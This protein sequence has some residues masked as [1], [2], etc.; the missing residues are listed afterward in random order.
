MATPLP[1]KP[2]I[3]VLP[4]KNM[5][6]DPEQEYFANGMTEDLI[7]DLSQVSA[8][9]VFPQFDIV[10]KNKPV[11]AKQI[12]RELGVRYLLEGSVQR[13]GDRVRINAQLIDGS[14][15]AICGR[16]DTMVQSPISF[17][18]KTK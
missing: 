2:S 8:L 15:A 3:A 12:A 1:D 7:T 11:D 6:A 14:A 9:F 4:F 13:S 10:Y 5:S 16:T 18:C 17:S